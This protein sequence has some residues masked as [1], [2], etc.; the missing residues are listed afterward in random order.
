MFIAFPPCLDTYQNVS[1]TFPKFMRFLLSFWRFGQN[2]PVCECDRI[3]RFV[4]FCATFESGEFFTFGPML[5]NFY[6]VGNPQVLV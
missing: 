6:K 3:G 4:K 2:S 5:G 1:P